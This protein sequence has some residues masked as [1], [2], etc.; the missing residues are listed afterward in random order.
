[1]RN[2]SSGFSFFF[3][4]FFHFIIPFIRIR[5]QMTNV[6]NINDT[7]VW[8]WQLDPSG[9]YPDMPWTKVPAVVGNNVIYNSVNFGNKNLYSVTTR[10]NDQID[11]NFTDGNFGNLPSGNFQLFYRQS[12]GLTYTIKPNQMLGILVSIPYLS[13]NGSNETL[14]LT[15]SLQYTVSNSAASETN[16]SIQQNAPQTYYLQNRMVTGEDYNTFPYANHP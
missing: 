7:D 6:S 1:M 9:N 14:T 11:I 15:L 12:N 13:K 4:G 16:A 3:C 10:D 5:S 2:F 8:L